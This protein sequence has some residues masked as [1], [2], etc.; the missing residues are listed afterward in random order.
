MIDWVLYN[1]YKIKVCSQSLAADRWVP[2]A[3]I[4]KLGDSSEQLHT[5][6][7]EPTECCKNGKEADSLALR[8]AKR[9]T[10]QHR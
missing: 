2:L 1:D 9:W 7:G 3:L 6:L 8:K 10:D 4:L 5:V